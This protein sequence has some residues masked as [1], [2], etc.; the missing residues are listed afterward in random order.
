M[1]TI[2]SELKGSL[3]IGKAYVVVIGGREHNVCVADVTDDYVF[4]YVAHNKTL[5]LIDKKGSG[6]AIAMIVRAGD[7]KTAV[8]PG[9][10]LFFSTSVVTPAAPML[11]IRVKTASI[12]IVED[13]W[14]PFVPADLAAPSG[15]ILNEAA[16]VGI[17]PS[18][19]G[20]YAKGHGFA[21]NPDVWSAGSVVVQSDPVLK[22]VGKDDE[23]SEE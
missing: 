6:R 3:E 8:T 9:D 23:S 20:F 12:D 15:Q 14:R 1:N 2:G 10:D 19:S 5:L 18:L 16:L 7:E 4:G 13:P 22:L 21:R 17:I 11:K